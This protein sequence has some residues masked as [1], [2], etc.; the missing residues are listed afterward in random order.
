MWRGVV[1]VA[2]CAAVL[3]TGAAAWGWQGGALLEARA[4]GALTSIRAKIEAEGGVFRHGVPSAD[5][6]RLRVAIPS[7]EAAAADGSSLRAERLLV[8]LAPWDGAL[9]IRLEEVSGT[10]EGVGLRARALGG[11][12]SLSWS[13]MVVLDAWASDLRIEDARASGRRAVLSATSARADRLSRAGG[14]EGVVAEG[15]RV[16]QPFDRHQWGRA[17]S[18]G[19][20]EATRLGGKGPWI[21]TFRITAREVG[22]RGDGGEIAAALIRL[23]GTLD[24]ARSEGLLSVEKGRL[25]PSG[26]GRPERF[27]IGSSWRQEGQGLE[28]GIDVTLEGMAAARASVALRDLPSTSG[29]SSDPQD[30][31]EAALAFSETTL[32]SAS[33]E[34]QDLGGLPDWLSAEGGG[35]RRWAETEGRGAARGMPEADRAV[36][37]VVADFVR[38]PG[39]RTLVIS[40]TPP[41]P[42]T[43]DDLGRRGLFLLLGAGAG[44]LG[45]AAQVR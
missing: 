33:L 40:A 8:S 12:P 44:P 1:A 38:A 2:A 18:V 19:R 26:A 17:V 7:P 35:L 21:G 10:A 32:A 39:G 14:A 6:W 41:Q 45:L 9:G 27:A 3:G 30:R 28:M 23:E 31:L 43:M 11:R 4:A 20:I 36:R 13:D 42:L 22:L 25:P 34:I 15:V 24:P 16:E 5:P 37:S 29:V